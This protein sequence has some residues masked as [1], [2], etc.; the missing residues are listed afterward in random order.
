MKTTTSFSMK[1][2]DEL[3]DMIDSLEG[4]NDDDVKDMYGIDTVEEASIRFW[5]E[6]RK[7]GN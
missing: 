1:S 5:E 3:K 7:R 6:Y 4:M 2:S